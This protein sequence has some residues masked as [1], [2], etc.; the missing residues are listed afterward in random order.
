MTQLATALAR[1]L[2]PVVLAAEIG[3]QPPDPWQEDV[4]RSDADRILLNVHRQGGKDTTAAVIAAHTALYEPKSLTLL[5]SP[6][7]RQSKELLRIVMAL[8]QSIGRAVPSQLENQLTLELENG[9]RIVSLPGLE[10][11]VRTFS[12]ARL[13]IINEAA[14]V[15]DDLYRAVR[16]MVAVSGGRIIAMST[17]WGRRGW[18]FEEWRGRQGVRPWLRIKVPATDC[19]R[20]S[21][22]FLEEE[23]RTMG[24]WWFRQEYMCEFLDAES[25]PFRTQ[26]IEAM[27]EEEVEQWHL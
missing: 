24:D 5:F 27:F 8:Y 11:N 2:D 13:I 12:A 18:F 25:Q 15:L 7:E 26:D 3:M 1:A 23:R 6:T 22:K 19:S 4:M 21:P 16:P 20:I 14:R 17:P 9:S 10:K